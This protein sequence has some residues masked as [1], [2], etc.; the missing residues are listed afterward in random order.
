MVITRETQGDIGGGRNFVGEPSRFKGVV[1]LHIGKRGKEP[2][3]PE[4]GVH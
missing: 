4:P 2:L 1:E 3:R